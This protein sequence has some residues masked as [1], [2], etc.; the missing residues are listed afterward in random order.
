MSFN[1]KDITSNLSKLI[2]DNEKISLNT[3]V[4]KLEKAS[5]AYPEDRTF[6]IMKDI[7]GRM[8][9]G[10]KTFITRAEI[11]DLYNKLYTR[12][13]KFAELFK[14]ELG[15]V[16]KLT[17]S[18][19]YNRESDDNGLTLLN[20]AYDKVV[21]PVLA[22][23][24]NAAFG[25]KIKTYTESNAK[26]A[27]DLCVKECNTI[28]L[29]ST[30][31]IINGNEKFILCKAAF[32][33]PKGQTAI[34]IPIEFN[35]KYNVLFPSIYIG[36]NGPEKFSK[37]NIENYLTLNAGQK[38]NINE[39]T[40]FAAINDTDINDVCNVDLAV[41]K[42]NSQKETKAYDTNGILFQKTASEDQ[43]LVVNTPKYKDDEIFSFAKSFDNASGISK[44]KFGEEKVNLGRTIISNKLNSFGINNHQISVFSSN[45]NQIVYAV[46]L[47]NG[48][49]A[50]RVP[51][52]IENDKIIEP[53][54]L[55]S[56]AAIE[57]FSKDGIKNLFTKESTD[58][59]TAAVASPLYGIKTS[60]L[61]QIVRVAISEQNYAKAEDALNILSN[62]EDDKAYKT[63]FELYTVGLN[64]NISTKQNTC[65][66]L[67]NNK[68][69][70]HTLCGHTGLPLHKVCQDKNDNCVPLYR[71]GMSDT[72]EGAYFMN[73]KILF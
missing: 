63:A 12:N 46:S 60:E 36:N 39:N 71:Q 35:T 41:I 57:S 4:F 50:F 24:L 59:T 65:N 69:S 56:N 42:F 6:G 70:K 13:T 68:T 54:I 8:S 21:D 43:N 14:S 19:I 48:R 30:V 29:A 67:V 2:D 62:S 53:N 66:M 40:I 49:I 31:D 38:L 3:F 27:K 7:A 44:F 11:K 10:K 34:F 33:T 25:N 26:D 55:I 72:R 22:N 32:E 64:G 61:V 37:S 47:N 51:V 18:Q 5:E 58:Y 15:T 28:S 9:N 73:S 16:E 23:A 17:S 45:E 1:Y 20:R 52:K